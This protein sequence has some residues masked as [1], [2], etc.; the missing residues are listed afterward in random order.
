MASEIIEIPITYHTIDPFAKP[1]A[2]PAPI[3]LLLSDTDVLGDPIPLLLAHEDQPNTT[4]Y[5]HPIVNSSSVRFHPYKGDPTTTQTLLARSAV[6][7]TATPVPTSASSAMLV[8]QPIITRTMTLPTTTT[9]KAILMPSLPATSPA[10]HYPD[11][12]S[13]LSS[14]TSSPRM[15]PELVNWDAAYMK[16]VRSYMRKLV[17]EHLNHTQHFKDQTPDKLANVRKD[18]LL[19]F[20]GLDEYKEAWPINLLLIKH[21]NYTSA[22]SIKKA[23]PLL[24]APVTSRGHCNQT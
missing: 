16:T 23:A 6:T 17:N 13:E 15:S 18:M 5:K 22:E 1:T 7:S 21:L 9:P 12:E 11:N 8:N 3:V 20:P 2:P 19:K 4:N 24:P 14:I 10:D